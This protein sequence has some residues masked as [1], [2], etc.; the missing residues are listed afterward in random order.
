MDRAAAAVA[1]VSGRAASRRDEA[2]DRIDRASGRDVAD[3]GDRLREVGRLTLNFHPDRFDRRRRTVAA[4]LLAHG[5]YVSQW[6]TGHS[7]GGRSAVPGGVRARWERRLFDTAYD[8]AAPR[9]RPVYGSL[10]L[11][12][13]PHG[14][15]PRFGSSYVVVADHVRSRT[16]LCVGD[17]H[18]GPTDVGTVDEPWSILA[19]LVEQAAERSLLDR[20]LDVAGLERA[21]AGEQLL[22]R[23]SRA[24]DG[25]V[26]A[27]VHGGV[28]LATDVAAIVVD[29][30]FRSTPVEAD[31]GRAAERFGFA[32]AWHTGS[33]L[34]ADEVP[35]GFRPGD[36]PA[37]AR[38]V[39]RDGLVDAAAIGTA[40]RSHRPGPPQRE[41]DPHDS[42]L[43]QLKYLW[44]AVLAY[45][46]DAHDAP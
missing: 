26:E 14:G 11:L 18:D 36:L 13:D 3:L 10:D 7:N 25:Y 17:S 35:D 6:V 2:R 22:D 38:R 44:H 12:G 27:Q 33:Q 24:L 28:D 30:S 32:L 21:L 5:S 16:T 23:P 20:P 15:S 42:P 41:G 4:G 45:G 1:A 37:L 9:E 39:A 19:G 46:S 29:P 31:L 40:A 8:G 34:G 43:Q